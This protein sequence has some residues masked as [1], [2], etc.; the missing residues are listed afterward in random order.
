MVAASLARTSPSLFSFNQY[1]SV[2][3]LFL[4]TVFD[5]QVH[6]KAGQEMSLMYDEPLQM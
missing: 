6:L 1:P 3:R 4:P 2:K 5:L